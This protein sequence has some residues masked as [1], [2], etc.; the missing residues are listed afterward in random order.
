MCIVL[1]LSASIASNFGDDL[2]LLSNSLYERTP[3]MK[4]TLFFSMMAVVGLCLAAQNAQAQ[5][6]VVTYYQPTTVFSP[7]IT[8]A[9]VFAPAPVVTRVY[10]PVVVQPAPVVAAPLPVVTYYRA[11]VVTMQSTPQVVTRYRPIM[12]G[13]VS[14]VRYGWTP[15]VY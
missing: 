3:P 14:R 7:V 15:V 1:H 9:P 5:F 12:G 10:S 8:P 6:P 13:S 11:P 2:R 4:R